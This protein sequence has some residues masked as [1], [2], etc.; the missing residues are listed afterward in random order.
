MV[1]SI[2]DNGKMVKEQA[3]ACL[4]L[5][6]EQHTKANGKMTK[7]GAWE[8]KL[9]PTSLYTRELLGTTREK[10]KESMF[11]PMEINIKE[12]GWMAS[13]MAAEDISQR[14][15]NTNTMVILYKICLKVLE[16]RSFQMEMSTKENIQLER[17]MAMEYLNGGMETSTM[18]NGLMARNV[19]RAV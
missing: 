7:N 6:K 5:K 11:M 15:Q 4:N 8:L 14:T 9:I 1:N 10:E 19:V 17:C 18:D 13:N 12:T 3:K 16:R 2:R